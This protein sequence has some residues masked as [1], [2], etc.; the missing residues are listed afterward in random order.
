[1]RGGGTRTPARAARVEAHLAP[2]E[3]AARMRDTRRINVALQC[4]LET[5]RFCGNSSL[6]YFLR[7]MGVEATR[8]AALMAAD[9]RAQ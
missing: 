7:T 1:M 2:L 8:E 3:L 5:L 4:Q 6:V 9:P